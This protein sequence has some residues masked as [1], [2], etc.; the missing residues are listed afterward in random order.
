M[1]IY[2][3]LLERIIGKFKS[4]IY[5]SLSI[6][7]TPCPITEQLYIKTPQILTKLGVFGVLM[8]LIIHANF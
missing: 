8:V 4:I 5:S 3:E 1:G 2:K 7:V 6:S